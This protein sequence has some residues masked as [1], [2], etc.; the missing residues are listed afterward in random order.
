M[1][2]KDGFGGCG[3]GETPCLR[4]TPLLPLLLI[5]YVYLLIEFSIVV[6]AQKYHTF[7]L[8]QLG[9]FEATAQSKK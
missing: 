9:E 4:A 6:S 1:V 7:G 8:V 2:F 3:G 5:N